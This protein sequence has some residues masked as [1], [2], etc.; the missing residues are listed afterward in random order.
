VYR[1]TDGTRERALFVIDNAGVIEWSYLS[2]VGIT[3][4]ADGI[5][6]ALERLRAPGHAEAGSA[7]PGP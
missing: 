4:G 6:E 5:L 7:N 3:P 2:P 1:S